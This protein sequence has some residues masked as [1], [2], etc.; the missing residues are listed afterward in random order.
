MS[1]ANRNRSP[2]QAEIVGQVRQFSAGVVLFNQKVAERVRLHPTDLQCVNLL[3]TL[4]ASTPGKLAEFTGLTTGG[5]TVMLDRLE[6]AGYIK[7][8][9]NPCDRRSLLVRVST[10]KMEKIDVH[11][12]GVAK[13]FDAYIA[14]VSEADLEV[15]TKFFK[16]MNAIRIN[17]VMGADTLIEQ[18]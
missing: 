17:A 6:K 3:Y 5:V 4:G 16:R 2:L 18:S 1:V 10:K 14:E 13:E 9:P 7:R 8:E 15:V 12:A 11:Y